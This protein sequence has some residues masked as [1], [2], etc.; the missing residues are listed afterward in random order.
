MRTPL[1]NGY[2]LVLN[3]SS[4]KVTITI[5]E[6]IGEGGCCIAYKGDL[7]MSTP[8]P[9]VIKECFPYNLALKR[10]DDGHSIVPENDE[11][12]EKVINAFESRKNRFKEGVLYTEI[13][14]SFSN[15]NE[16]FIYGENNN[17]WYCFSRYQNGKIL[18]EYVK[19]RGGNLSISETADLINSLCDSIMRY[20]NAG[21]LYLDT[22]PDN[23]FITKDSAGN[24]VAK[25]IDFDSIIP[26]KKDYRIRNN[27]CSYSRGWAAPEQMNPSASLSYKT[28]VFSVGAVFYWCLTSNKPYEVPDSIDDFKD[29]DYGTLKKIQDNTIDWR[30]ESKVCA[31]ANDRTISLIQEIAIGSLPKEQD[32]RKF[33]EFGRELFQM[34]DS[35]EALSKVARKGEESYRVNILKQSTNR[36]RYNSNTTVFR[37]R[38][39]EIGKL[40]DMCNS[41][42]QFRWIG[43][44]GNGG[45]G[46]SRLAYEL[47]SRMMKQFWVVYPPMHYR[48]DLIAELKEQNDNILICLD[49]VKQ[50]MDSITDFIRSIIETPFDNQFKIR[51]V[52]IEREE[53]DI[54]IDDFEIN[55]KRYS[56]PIVLQPIQEE[57]VRRIVLDYIA[58]Q[59]NLLEVS[60]EA[61]DLIIKTLEKV[62]QNNRRPIYALFIADAWLNNEKLLKWDR[63]NAL[64]YLLNHEL[65]R[66]NDQLKNTDY[67]LDRVKRDKY[68]QA[69]KYLYAL[70]TYEGKIS[71]TTF[72]QT[73]NDLFGIDSDDEMLRV[74]MVEFG[75]LSDD[76]TIDGWEPDLLGEY[77]CLRYLDD[78][79]NQFGDARVKAFIKT[80]TNTNFDSFIRYSEMMYKD[81]PDLVNQYQW[82]DSICDVEL[83]SEYTTVRK[84]MFENCSFLKHIVFKGRVNIIYPNAFKGCINL[85]SFTMPSSLEIIE[86]YAFYGCSSLVSVTPEDNVGQNPSVIKIMKYAFCGCTS[87]ETM[88]IPFSV[89]D[90]EEC[91]FKNCK[92]LKIVR[93]PRKV[94][95]IRCATFSG[96]KSL[97]NVY[98]R[99]SDSYL[100]IEKYSFDGCKNLIDI[101]SSDRIISIGAGAFRNCKQLKY[102]NLSRISHIEEDAF[103]GCA[104]L[105]NVDFS[106]GTINTIPKNLFYN[107]K[108]LEEVILSDT[109]RK[110]GDR[111]HSG[112]KNQSVAFNETIKTIE[113]NAFNGCEKLRFL[114]MPNSLKRI[115]RHAFKN[116]KELF[117]IEFKSAPKVIEAQA[118]EGCSKLDYSNIHGLAHQGMIIYSGFHFSSF[119][120]SDYYFVKSIENAK[121]IIVPDTV[122]SIDDNCF[123]DNK[124]I[125]SIKLPSSVRT[126]GKQAFKNCVNLREVI[127]SNSSIKALGEYAFEGCYNLEKIIGSFAIKNIP[128]GAFKDC[129]MLESISIASEIKTY[130]IESFKGCQNLIKIKCNKNT[131]PY[132]IGRGAFFGCSKLSYPLSEID[133]NQNRFI[134]TNSSY[135]GFCFKKITDI[136]IEFLKNWQSFKVIEV[137]DSCISVSGIDFS[138]I[139][140]LKKVIIPDSIDSLPER[141]FENCTDLECVILPATLRKL[142]INAF[143]NCKSLK[144]VI[145][146]GY[147]PNI[148]PDNVNVCKAVF[149]GCKKLESMVMPRNCI[150]IERDL[151]SG[152]QSLK[153]IS[154][155]EKVK[156]I[157]NG[158]FKDCIELTSIELPD[159][160]LNLGYCSFEGCKSLIKVINMEN[161]LLPAINNNTFKDCHLLESISLPNSLTTIRGQAFYECHQL[162][163]PSTFI[164]NSVEIIESAAFQGCSNIES[165]RLPSKISEISEY[166]FKDCVSLQKIFL[167]D[168]VEIIRK[169]AFF[170]C[171]RLLSTEDLL[172]SKLR[173]FG[174]D[175]FAYCSSLTELS[176][177]D[178]IES[179]SS[180]L[181]KSCSAL[182]KVCLPD[183][184]REISNDCFKDCIRLQNIN[185]PESLKAINVGAFRNCRS[186]TSEALK[187]PKGLSEIED[188]AFRYCDSISSIRLPS[189]IKGISAAM[190]EGCKELTEVLF[191]HH[192]VDVGTYAFAE[193]EKLERFPF[194]L[195]DH[196]IEIAAFIGCKSLLSPSFSD[197][198]STIHPSAFRGCS[199]IKDLSLPASLKILKGASFRGNDSLESVTIPNSVTAIEKS[200]FKDCL[201]LS[202]VTINAEEITISESV[203]SGC[204]NL[205]YISI[206]DNNR[207]ATNA[208]ELCPVEQSLKEQENINWFQYQDIKEELSFKIRV[209][210]LNN[211]ICILKYIGSFEK[212]IVVPEKIQGMTVT[213]IGSNCF[214]RLT[215]VETIELPDSIISIGR[216]AFARCV[217][218]KNITIPK[219]LQRIGDCAFRNC[220]SISSF[221]LPENM[222]EIPKGL[223]MYCWNLSSVTIHN[224]I[225]IIRENA[226]SSCRNLS[227]VIPESV[228]D[229]EANAF[230]KCDRTKIQLSK[231]YSD[232]IWEKPA[233]TDF[234]KVTDL[235]QYRFEYEIISNSNNI[236]LTHINGQPD[237][238]IIVPEVIDGH[239]VIAIGKEC[240]RECY[241]IEEI[242]L[243]NTIET[244]SIAAF[245]FCENLKS[246]YIPKGVRK[247]GMYSFRN[248]YSLREV[249]LPESVKTITKGSFM[250]CWNLNR[251]V[252]PTELRKIENRAFYSCPKLCME[253]PKGV[254]KIE[255]GAFRMCD[256]EKIIFNTEE[257]DDKWF[258]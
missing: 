91:A 183:N 6:T 90:I 249:Y 97:E 48:K 131:I 155:P 161:T 104:S 130:G 7:Q 188:S 185:L 49:Y 76:Y 160:L 103:A 241:A 28:D 65:M 87:L 114:N 23:I 218:L 54:R 216:N 80:V 47:C 102:V 21:Y 141:V 108:S 15:D 205:N 43:I 69:I 211:E 20:H 234:E 74:L 125:Q 217:N 167:P 113:Y 66:L 236:I 135:E 187:F 202:R 70:A 195:I 133:C 53:K 221:S 59:N 89:Q 122:I 207:V 85:K 225:K 208:F 2:N 29:I 77:Y 248:C 16:Y 51:V 149:S 142:P 196:G 58:N 136:E 209:D 153:A 170:N 192:I 144:T 251:I 129:K 107:C 134:P 128:N 171:V 4:S 14:S 244:I 181:F 111:S 37:G 63:N 95:V 193:C 154:I 184:I 101:H 17:T 201:N 75:I 252:L 73:L 33:G 143:M 203:F 5:K 9:V 34:K 72:D 92:S 118:F 172:P 140:G 18:T 194:H 39:E 45:T 112:F 174:D 57:Q 99:Y 94:S 86:Q 224:N 190:F 32:D 38:E 78:I 116:C 71:I 230:A 238:V 178:S 220:Y 240:F 228:E 199:S 212:N 243:P 22:K 223:F 93:I 121:E 219:G 210:E 253:I 256:R 189:G 179:L 157:E 152:C 250:Y 27:P 204:K 41:T 137:P 166:L 254:L 123:M 88:I 150:S 24:I 227:T 215:C 200:A 109:I 233:E 12:A 55:L 146:R 115:G 3:T 13:V 148:I 162:K 163:V 165:L 197:S 25:V 242:V 177:P 145:F 52:L 50:D 138:S 64:D 147:K 229:I 36:F 40:I 169:C 235:M 173:L 175:A 61:L 158:A 100:T 255:P 82:I 239:K 11:D 237:P 10:D 119:S 156:T 151:F 222:I 120:K 81:Y 132:L 110:K 180:G 186:L 213:A 42:D 117:G 105:L 226:F 246:I 231:S 46:K 139:V 8:I 62:D 198:I 98:F 258:K 26:L 232:Y 84:K 56:P 68:S 67:M 96:C 83:P 126:I 206:P 44:C 127:C 159:G 1:P 31:H 168:S 257:I 182:V 35:L 191:D 30:S 245:A 79:Y 164:P 124:S 176:I 247:I 106:H 19:D 60:E 214:E